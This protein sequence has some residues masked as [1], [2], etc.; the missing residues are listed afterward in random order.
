MEG[1]SGRKRVNDAALKRQIV[2]I[3]D[4]PTQQAISKV[5]KTLDH[6]IELNNRITSEL[7]AMA[8]TLFDYWFIQFDFP[9]VKQTPYKASGGKMVFSDKLKTTIPDDW[10]SGVAS[11]L[12]DFNPSLTLKKNLNSSY[13]DMSALPESG[14]M[15][16]EVQTK[17]YNGGAKFQNGDLVLARITPCLE[18]GKTGL[19]TLLDLN[20]V[21]FGSTE[22]IV[23]R[24]KNRPLSSF[25]ACLS[26]SDLFRK[27]A[28]T[29]MTGTSGRK[30]VE[31]DI[32][33]R[34]P[35]AIPPD[36][37]L[38]EFEN[39][40]GSFF[41]IATNNVRQNQQL[42]ELRDWLLPMLMNGQVKVADIKEEL[43]MVAEEGVEYR[44]KRK[45]KA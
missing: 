23:L 5:L 32:L 20:E 26:R 6:K 1:T 21:G 45:Q 29:N 27:Y 38:E 22:F 35:M 36:H 40:V 33:A 28:I 44:A 10:K 31:A 37:L 39:T 25:A 3:P 41:K 18:N 9:H 16:R 17:E 34:F 30:R 13:I 43:A 7:E 19:I 8:K 42:A 14:F 4:L 11:D 12:F 15:T 2:P 24:G